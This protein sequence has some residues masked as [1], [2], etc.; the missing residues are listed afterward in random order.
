MS[1]RCQFGALNIYLTTSLRLTLA[2][3]VSLIL[4]SLCYR[5]VPSSVPAVQAYCDPTLLDFT[6]R[7][8]RRTPRRRTTWCWTSSP[9]RPPTTWTPWSRRRSTRTRRTRASAARPGPPPSPSSPASRRALHPCPAGACAAC[10]DHNASRRRHM[11]CDGL[12]RCGM[13]SGDEVGQYPDHELREL[14]IGHTS[15]RQEHP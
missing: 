15:W 7:R 5:P 2:S 1:S 12:R 9:G 4:L 13:C 14:S 8:G 3:T 10:Y 11:W 6:H